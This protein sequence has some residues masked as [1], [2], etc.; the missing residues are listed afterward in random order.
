ML[1]TRS[2]TARRRRPGDAGMVSR[3]GT[4][5]QV[6]LIC[7]LGVLTRTAA[8]EFEVGNATLCSSGH[9]HE[10]DPDSCARYYLC[11]PRIILRHCQP[12]LHFNV[13]K[14]TCV[15]PVDAKC[16]PSITAPPEVD[17]L[18]TT[19]IPCPYQCLSGECLIEAQWCNGIPD[20][21]DL[22]DEIN[23]RNVCNN[24]TCVLPDC[25]CMGTATPNNMPTSMIPQIVTLTFEGG[26]R[27]Q[28]YDIVYNR[29]LRRGRKNPNGCAISAT[30][31]VSHE[32]TD[33]V[34]VKSLYYDGHEM[35]AHSISKRFPESWWRKASYKEW[36][37]EI[38]EERIM[39]N[40]LGDVNFMDVR[41]MR[42]PFLQV[43]GNTQFQ[44]LHNNRFLYDSSMPV[45]ES[46]PP[47]WPFTLDIPSGHR[48]IR[49]PCPTKRFPGL[50]EV[51]LVFLEGDDGLPCA[52]LDGC[53]MPRT[54]TGLIRVLK[55][56]FERHYA[57]NRA[58]LMLSLSSR[59]FT[60][61]YAD[62]RLAAMEE[63][64]DELATKDDVWL[65]TVSEMI[66]WIRNPAKLEMMM[67]NATTPWACDRTRP[68]PC[69]SDEANVCNYGTTHLMGDKNKF[70]RTCSKCPR[71]YPWV[72]NPSGS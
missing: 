21:R 58:P 12:G 1:L 69:S 48:C 50:W 42:A 8:G 34:A 61:L 67:R 43:G 3:C 64:L 54:K 16:D 71:R 32:Y 36:E 10:P 68:E 56:N 46:N 41:G 20:C 13:K 4:L 45:A 37:Q 6:V 49:S 15:W 39:L 18:T 53:S 27:Q 62:A 5:D 2:C 9:T 44:M 28:D 25:A 40:K 66:A 23:C 72:G 59:W 65:L 26:I 31:F 63:F 38:A 24:Y 33:Y 70:V 14:Q 19:A 22:T 51:P 55:H 47:L 57:S 11:K 60:G 17:T 52:T 29:I 30:F 7:V 35:A